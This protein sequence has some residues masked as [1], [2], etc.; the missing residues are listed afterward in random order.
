MLLPLTVP[1]CDLIQAFVTYGN[2]LLDWIPSSGL[3]QLFVLIEIMS[4]SLVFLLLNCTQLLQAI[5][6]LFQRDKANQV[7]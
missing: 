5:V 4:T 6:Q 2:L 1:S 3:V 7:D